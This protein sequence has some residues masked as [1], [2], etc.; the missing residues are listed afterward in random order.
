MTHSTKYL[1][2]GKWSKTDSNNNGGTCQRKIAPKRVKARKTIQDYCN[3]GGRL[4]SSPLKQKAGVV[5]KHWSELVVKS[6][7][8]LGEYVVKVIGHGCLLIDRS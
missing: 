3:K 2:H 7:R 6:W 5:F 1:A 4:N 8:I